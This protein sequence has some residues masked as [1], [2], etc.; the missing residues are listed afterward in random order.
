MYLFDFLR[1]DIIVSS[2]MGFMGRAQEILRGNCSFILGDKK[3]T[4]IHN[5]FNV[6]DFT[7]TY[8]AQGWYFKFLP[9][10][11]ILAG[12]IRTGNFSCN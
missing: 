11:V 7:F 10:F 9:T 8:L 4:K 5:V 6:V 12:I 3:E 1:K 2:L